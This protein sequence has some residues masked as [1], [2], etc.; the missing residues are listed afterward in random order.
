MASIGCEAMILWTSTLGMHTT[1][2]GLENVQRW[3]SL[4]LLVRATTSHGDSVSKPL[5]SNPCQQISVMHV[6]FG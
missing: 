4:P 3:I 2:Q 6:A 1:G 5:E